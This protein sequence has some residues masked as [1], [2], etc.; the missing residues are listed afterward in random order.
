MY[1]SRCTQ[2]LSSDLLFWG[3]SALTVNSPCSAQWA[4]CAGR[5]RLCLLCGTK[6]PTGRLNGSVIVLDSAASVRR[7]LN[8]NQMW[9]WGCLGPWNRCWEQKTHTE[10]A[11]PLAGAPRL[12]TAQ[13]QLGESCDQVYCWQSERELSWICS[14]NGKKSETL[15][16]LNKQLERIKQLDGR[17]RVMRWS[18]V[19]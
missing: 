2:L 17:F 10:R 3:S 6:T 8:E 1:L 9:L 19:L 15:M 5:D 4:V 16:Q 7:A 18:P 14:P 11:R 13:Q 12:E